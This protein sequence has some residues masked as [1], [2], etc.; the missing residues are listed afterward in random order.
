MRFCVFLLIGL[1]GV[2]CGGP[3]ERGQD[4][5]PDAVDLTAI[6]ATPAGQDIIEHLKKWRVEDAE[7]NYE[8]DVSRPWTVRKLTAAVP[9]TKDFN[10]RATLVYLLAASRNT[11]GLR[12]AAAALDDRDPHVRVTAALAITSYWIGP[13]GDGDAQST[14]IKAKAWWKRRSDREDE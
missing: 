10:Q 5:E 13:L 2:A 7:A 9:S 14:L 1:V 3:Q 6:P 11:A 4:E 8:I 12:A